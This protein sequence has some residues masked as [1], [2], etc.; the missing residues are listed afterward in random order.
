M[1]GPSLICSIANST[2]QYLLLRLFLL[3]LEDQSLLCDTLLSP[4]TGSLGLSTLG[5]HL[6]LENLLTLLL[7]LGLVDLFGMLACMR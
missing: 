5:V 1:G 2:M 7:G 6:F 4:L 3:T